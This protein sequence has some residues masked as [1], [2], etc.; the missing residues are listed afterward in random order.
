MRTFLRRQRHARCSEVDPY[1]TITSGVLDDEGS[2]EFQIPDYSSEN[3]P[4]VMQLWIDGVGIA[5]EGEWMAGWL[6]V[7][8][9]GEVSWGPST[10]DAGS[11]S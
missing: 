9:S 8:E 6:R 10:E 11:S 4:P 7:S 2:L 3:Q 1:G 5:D